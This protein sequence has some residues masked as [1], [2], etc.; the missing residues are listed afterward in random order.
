MLNVFSLYCIDRLTTSNAN[1]TEVISQIVDDH[2]DVNG[3][4]V[5]QSKIISR[6]IDIVEMVRDEK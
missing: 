6:V 3:A 1:Q 4:I 2:I 5:D